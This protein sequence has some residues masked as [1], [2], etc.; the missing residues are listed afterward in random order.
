[1]QDTYTVLD[2]PLPAITSP[3]LHE[4]DYVLYLTALHRQLG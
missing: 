2:G 4:R 1:M 3:E